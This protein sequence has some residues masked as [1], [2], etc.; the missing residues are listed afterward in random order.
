MDVRKVLLGWLIYVPVATVVYALLLNGKF[1]RGG[2]LPGWLIAA[3]SVLAVVAIAQLIYWMRGVATG[4]V[5][6][7]RARDV[8]GFFWMIAITG[9]IGDMLAVVAEIAF[10]AG[11]LWL[12]IPIAT[13]TY[14]LSVGWMYHRYFKPESAVKSDP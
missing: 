10:G 12:M 8:S 13:I 14:A 1:G 5:S 3:A 9:A 2:E 4:R 6:R 7:D 11:A